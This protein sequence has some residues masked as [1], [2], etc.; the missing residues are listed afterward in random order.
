MKKITYLCVAI[1]IFLSLGLGFISDP[2]VANTKG[3]SARRDIYLN[4][5]TVTKPQALMM[6]KLADGKHNI[7]Y[8]IDEDKNV[9]EYEYDEEIIKNVSNM[10]LFIYTGSGYEKWA[11]EF[12]SKL[13]KNNLG[14]IDLSRG[15]RTKENNPYYL[16]GYDQYKIA[17]YNA[18]TAL[19]DRDPQNRDYYETNYKSI[20][21]ELESGLEVSRKS[22]NELLKDINLTYLSTTDEYDYFFESLGIVVQKVDKDNYIDVINELRNQ[23]KQFVLFTGKVQNDEFDFEALDIEPLILIN[24]DFIKTY[25]ET[26]MENFNKIIDKIMD[27]KG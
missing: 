26:I 2:L 18:K 5:M 8:L 24:N 19:Q 7:D 25:E 9:N 27:I 10:D 12:I 6:K 14:I 22:Y 21:S 11:N 3:E 16:L 15:T 4:I 13:D 23:E 17:L 20:I 1:T